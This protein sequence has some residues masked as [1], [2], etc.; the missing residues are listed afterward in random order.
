MSRRHDDDLGIYGLPGDVSPWDVRFDAED[1]A[2]MDAEG[3]GRFRLC[4]WTEAA[5]GAARLV[6]RT[7]RKV[8]SY[9]MTAVAASDRFT[10]WET[11]A[12][13]FAVGAR[14][15]FAFRADGG[16]G[17]GVYLSPAGITVAL[18]R[19][20]RV[21]R[22]APH[23]AGGPARRGPARRGD[24]RR[25]PVAAGRRLRRLHELPAARAGAALLRDRRHQGRD[26][27]SGETVGPPRVAGHAGRAQ[28]DRQPRHAAFPHP[29]GR[30]A[31][32]SAAGDGAADDLPR[33]AGPLLRGRGGHGRW[34]RPRL[35]PKPSRCRTIP[36][37]T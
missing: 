3:D 21:A 26:G 4:V 17:Q 14:Y 36:A 1:R 12:G 8:D 23:A 19:S 9:A 28:P 15:S 7:G 6:V 32:A 33:R 37:S 16:Y 18:R 25:R 34:R 27:R 35:P 29:G 31:L 20:R 30:R 22:S 24:G 2:L 10:F 5:L 11:V 13:P